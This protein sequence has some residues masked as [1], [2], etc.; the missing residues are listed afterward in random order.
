MQ[1]L[2][3]SDVFVQLGKIAA[4]NTK[5]HI[6]KIHGRSRIGRVCIVAI[7]AEPGVIIAGDIKI[8]VVAGLSAS[9]SNPRP[10]S[11]LT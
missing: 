3:R 6:A 5:P 10:Y 4:C 2:R 8:Y 7:L 11:V 9:M 1:S